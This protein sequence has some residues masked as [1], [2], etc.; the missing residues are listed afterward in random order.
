M[1]EMLL[2]R[3]KSMQNYLQVDFFFY[4]RNILCFLNTAPIPDEQISLTLGQ[5]LASHG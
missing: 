2:K 3:T 5:Q 4:N 1:I